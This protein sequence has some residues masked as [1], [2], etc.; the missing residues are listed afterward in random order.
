M[1]IRQIEDKDYGAFKDLFE[2]AYG[3]Y[4]ESLKDRDPQE[5]QRELEEGRKVTR[6]RF[7]FYLKTGSSFVAEDSEVIGY[8]VSQTLNFMRG[9]DRLLWI[10]YVVVKKKFRR[11]GIG[12]ALLRK[13]TEHAKRSNIDRIYTTIN[14]DNMASIRLH[15]KAGFDVKDWRTASYSV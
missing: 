12:L 14:P 9:F 15:L 4:L 1:I 6:A 7:E 11:R 3:E 13:L 10:E 2:E 8:V 5:Y